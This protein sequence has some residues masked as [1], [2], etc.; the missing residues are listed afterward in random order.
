MKSGIFNLGLKF[1]DEVVKFDLGFKIYIVYGLCEEFGF[2]DLVIK[3]Y[4]DML[5]VVLFI[6]FDFDFDVFLL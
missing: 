5:D 4:C 6:F 1:L 2:G 3:L